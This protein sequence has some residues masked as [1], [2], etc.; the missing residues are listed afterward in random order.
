MTEQGKDWI[1]ANYT[2]YVDD[3]YHYMD[4]SER[5]KLGEFETYD[6]ALNAAKRIVEDYINRAYKEGMSARELLE[7][8]KSFG[9]DPYIDPDDGTP[10]FSAWDYAEELC[11]KLC[12]RP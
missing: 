8:Y 1:M 4:E 2:V 7:S 5:Y 9:E 12:E 6:D 11:K 10:K 3:N